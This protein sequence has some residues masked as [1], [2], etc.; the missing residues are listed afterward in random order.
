MIKL[1][2][3]TFIFCLV[4]LAAQAYVVDS[5]GKPDIT[6]KDMEDKVDE[7]VRELEVLLAKSYYGANHAKSK[8]KILS[9]DT[10]INGQANGGDGS[11]KPAQN[12]GSSPRH[13]PVPGL[14]SVIDPSVITNLAKS[15]LSGDA[16]SELNQQLSGLLANVARMFAEASRLAQVQG[17]SGRRT[18]DSSTS[19]YKESTAL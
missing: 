16:A 1:A 11:S 7:L 19:N 3:A 2:F 14:G 9:S 8:G 10:S 13:A 6:R 5:A 18:M 17:Q 4:L 12:V 15:F